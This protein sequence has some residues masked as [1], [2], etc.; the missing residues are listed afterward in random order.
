MNQRLLLK[1]INPYAKFHLIIIK[2]EWFHGS[3]ELFK[4]DS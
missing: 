1:Q 2:N 4:K 3:I